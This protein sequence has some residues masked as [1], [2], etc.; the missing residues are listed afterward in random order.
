[1]IAKLDQFSLNLVRISYTILGQA[2]NLQS[3]KSIKKK[4]MLRKIVR[5]EKGL[6]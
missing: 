3:L 1:M 6:D 4:W 2:H 5:W